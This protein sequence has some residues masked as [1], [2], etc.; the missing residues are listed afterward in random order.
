MFCRNGPNRPLSSC[1][2]PN[3]EA[4]SSTFVC[5]QLFP[6]FEIVVIIITITIF[7]PTS[8]TQDCHRSDQ[9]NHHHYCHP[10]IV[11]APALRLLPLANG[12]LMIINIIIIIMVIIIIILCLL[13]RTNDVLII[14]TI[15][16]VITVI[17]ITIITMVSAPSH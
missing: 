15:T 7:T 13:P 17:L 12:G 3:W 6:C 10:C 4:R 1:F 16:I 2:P 14:I 5:T 11:T 8:L 9:H